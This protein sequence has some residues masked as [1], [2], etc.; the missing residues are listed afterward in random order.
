M[1]L[2]DVNVLIYAPREDAPEH[3]RY[4]GVAAGADGLGRTFALS[5]VLLSGVLRIVTNP[6]IFDPAT[7]MD[8]AV[9]F[10]QRLMGWPRA[11]PITPSRRVRGITGITRLGDALRRRQDGAPAAVIDHA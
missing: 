11:S 8:A 2:P 4:A 3:E 5:D 6:R 7:P 10:C 1:Q 9:A